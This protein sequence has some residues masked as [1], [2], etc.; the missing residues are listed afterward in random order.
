[1]KNSLYT[2]LKYEFKTL[3]KSEGAI[4][5]AP[6]AY[7]LSLKPFTVE[8]Y[9]EG[10]PIPSSSIFFIREASEYLLGGEVNFC[11][12]IISDN[13]IFT[14]SFSSFGKSIT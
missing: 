14:F 3:P 5:L 11:S 8:A 12:E 9:V 4:D 2:P 6:K 10:L 7:F 13:L 1:M